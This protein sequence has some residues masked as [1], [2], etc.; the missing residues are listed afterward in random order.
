MAADAAGTS[1]PFVVAEL[2][3]SRCRTAVR[4]ATLTPA[5]GEVFAL[6]ASDGSH[7]FVD[8]FDHD[9]LSASDFLGRATCPPC[10]RPAIC[11]FPASGCTP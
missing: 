8:V 9:L 1:D 7:L 2:G 6:D 4:K 10:S 11:P 3:E 5:W